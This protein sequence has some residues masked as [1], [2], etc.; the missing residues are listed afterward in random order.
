MDNTYEQ[1]MSQSSLNLL[2]I[3]EAQA[4]VSGEK[5]MV[6]MMAF[7]D[8]LTTSILTIKRALRA[9]QNASVIFEAMNAPMAEAAI[10]GADDLIAVTQRAYPNFPE[11][12]TSRLNSIAAADTLV[13]LAISEQTRAA[14]RVLFHACLIFGR[15]PNG[16]PISNSAG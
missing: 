3:L 16:K 14:L 8:S 6:G 13:W 7:D 12:E 9:D 15:A 4:S 11:D 1:G 5:V 2:T 10:F